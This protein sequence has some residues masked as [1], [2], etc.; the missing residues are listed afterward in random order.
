VARE[1]VNLRDDDPDYPA[2]FVA[3]YI[4]GGGAGFESRLMTRIR[5]KEGLS[6]GVGSELAVGSEDR[7]GAWTAYAIA[8]PQNVAKVETA[9]REELARALKDGFTNAEVASAQTGIVSSRMQT[10]SQDAALAVPGPETSIS[11]A[12]SSGARS[13]SRR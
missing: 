4:L 3:D 8:A 6:Y 9:F 7:A 13:S 5:Q 12:P 2:L 1:N 11:G 10:R